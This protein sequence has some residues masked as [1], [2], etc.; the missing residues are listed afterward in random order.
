MASKPSKTLNKMTIDLLATW[1]IHAAFIIRIL[2]SDGMKGSS[3]CNDCA[4]PS[5]VQMDCTA[6]IQI[7]P[8]SLSAC[9]E[10]SGRKWFCSSL[11]WGVLLLIDSCD[12]VYSVFSFRQGADLVASPCQV[13]TGARVSQSKSPLAWYEWIESTNLRIFSVF[14]FQQ[15]SKSLPVLHVVG[16]W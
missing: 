13:R 8:L 9:S 10:K 4:C 15:M 3:I 5:L 2:I 7:L 14:R 11:C 16:T 1:T 6:T 12:Y